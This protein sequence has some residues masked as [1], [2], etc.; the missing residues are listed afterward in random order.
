MDLWADH[1]LYKK[2]VSFAETSRAETER[3][4][5]D[6]PE[7]ALRLARHVPFVEDAL[8][9]FH[10]ALDPAVPSIKRAMIWAP[11]LYFII[12]TDA[13][14]DFL[15][16]LGFADD[17]AAVGAMVAALGATMTDTH[18]NKARKMLGRPPIE[19]GKPKKRSK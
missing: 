17:A 16:G 19:G 18:R 1:P 3:V 6:L 15:P 8:A 7:L 5:R 11:L 12:P 4:T 9:A 13:V 10:T 2:A 14:P